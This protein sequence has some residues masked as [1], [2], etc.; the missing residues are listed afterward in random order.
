VVEALVEMEA[1]RDRPPRTVA[2]L[3]VALDPHARSFV[4]AVRGEELG[5]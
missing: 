3:L 2:E 5:G 4:A 1:D